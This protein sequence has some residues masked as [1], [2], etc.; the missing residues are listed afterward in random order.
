MANRSVV[1]IGTDE[2]PWTH[3]FEHT[4]AHVDVKGLPEGGSLELEFS[5]GRPEVQH[6]ITLAKNGEHP[7]ERPYRWV[8]AR[9]RAGGRSTIVEIRSR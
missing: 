7:L 6:T 9:Q 5:E 4:T 1:L 3:I 2:G 8:R